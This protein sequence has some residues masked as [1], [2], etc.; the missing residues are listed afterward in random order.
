M[1]FPF[2]D[3]NNFTEILYTNQ[4]A[5]RQ[6][7]EDKTFVVRKTAYLNISYEALIATSE[8][9]TNALLNM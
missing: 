3:D 2:P 6:H 8:S 5:W 1:G 7:E 9:E 4:Q